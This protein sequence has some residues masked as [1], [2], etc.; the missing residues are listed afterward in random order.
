MRCFGLPERDSSCVS[1]G[2]RTIT[3]GTFK[4]FNARNMIS[5][6]SAG[7]VLRSSSPSMNIVGV[8]TFAIC[9][10]GDRAA[11]SAGSSHG[12]L[13]NHDGVYCVKS[14]V[15]QKPDQSAIERIDTAA[16]KRV[17][18]VIVQLVSSPPPLPPV[19]PSRFGSM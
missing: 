7:G 14:A 8:L 12:A 16:A 13:R 6:P 10:I 15:Y 3:V 17:V 9:V 5:P 18:C 4:Y 1:P 11:K 2:T 19:T